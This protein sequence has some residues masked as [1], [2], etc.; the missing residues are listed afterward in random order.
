MRNIL[1]ILLS[2]G[3]FESQVALCQDKTDTIQRTLALNKIT[4]VFNTQ[5][6][7]QRGLYNGLEYYPYNRLFKGSAN[8]LNE[9]DWKKADVIYNQ[10]LFKN[11]IAK[12]DLAKDL[13]VVL[14]TNTNISFTPISERVSDFWLMDHHFV[15]L[16]IQNNIISPGFYDLRTDGK[17]KLYVKRSKTIK[18][19]NDGVSALEKI[20]LERVDYYI[21]E[22]GSFYRINS[23]GSFLNFFKDKKAKVR[24]YLKQNKINYSENNENYLIKG[25]MY[26]ETLK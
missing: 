9:K 4:D 5:M 26:Y 12:Y 25:T 10:V 18:N 13:L 14:D 20:F 15:Y 21:E 8:F 16:N 22:E 1:L 2:V 7:V 19:T 17:T 23:K 24:D 6:D 3:L 11:V